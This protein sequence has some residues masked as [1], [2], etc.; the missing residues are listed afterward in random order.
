VVTKSRYCLGCRRDMLDTEKLAK[1][2]QDA[3]QEDKAQK[4]G[5]VAGKIIGAVVGLVILIVV[6]L[7]AW[8][9]IQGMIGPGDVFAE[10]PTSRDQLV[11]SFLAN[12]NGGTDKD[13]EKALKLISQRETG[14]TNQLMDG[15]KAEL[16][17]F[18]EQ[19]I[20]EN[21]ADWYSKAQV[22]FP[23]ADQYLGDEV[24]A[25]VK[26]DKKIY[27]IGMQA[28]IGVDRAVAERHIPLKK[29]TPY[30]ENGKLHWGIGEIQEHHLVDPIERKMYRPGS[31][32]P[33]VEDDK[34]WVPQM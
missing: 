15:F 14:V 22:S 11:K 34:P 27:H 25:E 10:Y 13:Y 30:R 16:I 18:R 3:S 29:K 1:I 20:K 23:Q 6:G 7:V 17:R 19:L 33:D 31:D 2:M 24:F 28:Q 26:I 8:G 9:Q 21:G 12:L 4:I 32:A 5:K